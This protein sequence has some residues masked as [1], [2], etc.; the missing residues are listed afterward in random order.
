MVI[1]PPF[2]KQIYTFTEYYYFSLLVFA[3]TTI[4]VNINYTSKFGMLIYFAALKMQ[5][6][7][8]LN[9]SSNE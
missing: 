5:P 6:L 7:L 1:K 9:V 2:L 3:F 4:L 8:N